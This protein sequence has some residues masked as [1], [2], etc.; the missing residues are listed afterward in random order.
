MNLAEI[1]V[2]LGILGLLSGFF[3]LWS[4]RPCGN[5]DRP[6]TVVQARLISVIIPARN[7]E[8]NIK[9]LLSSFAVQTC[10]PGEIIV[11]DDH[12]TDRTVDEAA[13]LG[14]SVLRSEAL[15]PGWTG[16]NWACFQGAGKAGGETLL[17]LDADTWLPRA[18]S[19][20]ML[21]NEHLALEGV[22]S[23]APYHHTERLYEQLSAFFNII[24]L[25]S[26]NAFTPFG[27]NLQPQGLF[28]PCMVV[29]RNDYNRVGGHETVKNKVLENFF[30]AGHFR[31]QGIN[32]RCRS[33]ANV[34]SYRMYPNGIGELVHGW[35]KAFSQG[36]ARSGF[37]NVLLVAAW[38]SGQMVALV[39]MLYA[40]I[41]GELPLS[42][43]VA[44]FC[45]YALQIRWVLKRL[46]CFGRA[47]WMLFPVPLFFF[48]A[49]FG[50]SLSAGNKASWKG[51]S[52]PR[53]SD[54]M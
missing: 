25:A 54:G 6:P 44:L 16:K 12:S 11:V 39:A 53:Q 24:T 4:I 26:T 45:L 35:S 46:G 20:A 3:M 29:K 48:L 27:D 36:A 41:T 14:A 31:D 19:L 1:Y 47:A 33:G 18:D 23:I 7:E 22:M 43:A 37:W 13:R 49:L 9:R 5:I 28:G 15:P 8:H 10:K 52:I 21:I 32:I 30:L 34:L 38:I 50:Y 40:L 51:R 42:P 2:A 17:F